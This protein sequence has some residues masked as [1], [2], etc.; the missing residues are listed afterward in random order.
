[1]LQHNVQ[2]N[3][4]TGF[5]IPTTQNFLETPSEDAIVPDALVHNIGLLGKQQDLLIKCT[6][7][8]MYKNLANY[9]H[10]TNNEPVKPD[11]EN[12]AKNAPTSI[13]Q[14][15]LQEKDYSEQLYVKVKPDYENVATNA[16]S[17][18]LTILQKKDYS[19]QL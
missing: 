1:M 17:I 14:M 8:A 15:I 7:N 2:K 3:P 9:P 10:T 4:S 11:Y 16:T 13:L 19:E 6:R 12:V 5:G 18:L